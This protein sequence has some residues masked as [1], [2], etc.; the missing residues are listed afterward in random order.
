MRELGAADS[1]D[2]AISRPLYLGSLYF[3]PVYL[4]RCSRP[5]SSPALAPI[6]RDTLRLRQPFQRTCWV[7][8]EC[9]SRHRALT[10][11]EEIMTG[12][13][14]NSRRAIGS[15]PRTTT[16]TRMPTSFDGANL[17]ISVLK[18]RKRFWPLLAREQAPGRSEKK[19][20]S[21]PHVL[22]FSDIVPGWTAQTWRVPHALAEIL[23][24]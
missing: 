13:K 22:L 10:T 21:T 15:R 6:S 7:G 11:R 19:Q 18:G 16:S 9:A 4:E 14:L 3:G 17:S 23:R 5:V 12:T 24:R 2:V 8:I 20:L 1:F